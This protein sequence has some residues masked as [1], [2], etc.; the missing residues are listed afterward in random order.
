M[1]NGSDKT[2][3]F[4]DAL[5]TKR[6]RAPLKNVMTETKYL[7]FVGVTFFSLFFMKLLDSLILKK[8][9]SEILIACGNNADIETTSALK[10]FL[11]H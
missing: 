1:K 6:V 4:F 2:R 5:N 9:P 10:S 11:I 8:V 3:F 7:L